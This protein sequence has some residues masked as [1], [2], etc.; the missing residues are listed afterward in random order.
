MQAVRRGKFHQV[1]ALDGSHV[2][3][4]VYG[5]LVVRCFEKNG[6]SYV[7]VDTADALGDVDTLRRIDEYIRTK[8]PLQFSPLMP[9]MPNRVTLKLTGN[10]AYKDDLGRPAAPFEPVGRVDVVVRPGAFGSFGY[11]VLVHAIKPHAVKRA[12]TGP[13]TSAVKSA[14]ENAVK[15]AVENG[16]TLLHGSSRT[17]RASPETLAISNFLHEG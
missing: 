1:R 7:I 4:A 2:D 9:G 3:V 13:V 15:S 6:K 8:T 10:T 14:V 17:D 16:R 11:C 12:V 5:A